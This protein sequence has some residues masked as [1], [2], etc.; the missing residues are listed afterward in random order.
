VQNPYLG[1]ERPQLEGAATVQPQAFRRDELHAGRCWYQRLS[2]I[3][4]LLLM[5]KIQA[6]RRARSTSTPLAV[7]RGGK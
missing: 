1:L 3:S 4:S 5:L 6:G 2:N 7:G